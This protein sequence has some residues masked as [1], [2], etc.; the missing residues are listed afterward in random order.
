VVAVRKWAEQQQVHNLTVDELHTYYVIAGETPV[1]VHNCG[2]SIY[3]TPKVD[4]MAHELKRGP[5]PASH[6][7]GDASVYF[8]EKSVAGE[9]QGRGSCANGMIRYE[10]REDFLKEFGDT[11]FRY[12]RQGPGGSVRIEFVIPTARLERF[13]ELT[14]RRVWEPK[15]G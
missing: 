15:V 5:N 12:D 8:G 11:A 9:Y 6:Q 14:L 13:N 4:D 10:M 2:V 7:E 3:R 1:L